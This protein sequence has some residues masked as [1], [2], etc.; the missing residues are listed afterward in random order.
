MVPEMAPGKTRV[1]WIGTGV[2]GASMCGHVLAA[3]YRVTAYNRSSVKVKPLVER[4]ASE[5]RSP[6]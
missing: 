1:G 3:G 5:A 2:M 6:K 4:G